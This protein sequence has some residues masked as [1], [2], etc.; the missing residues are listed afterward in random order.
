MILSRILLR[1]RIHNIRDEPA[2]QE[3]A[4]ATIPH[5]TAGSRRSSSSYKN[6]IQGLKRSE[7]DMLL[8]KRWAAK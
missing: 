4:T 6:K 3:A 7:A 8:R 1:S 5:F 2:S